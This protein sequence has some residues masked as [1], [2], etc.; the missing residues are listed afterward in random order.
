MEIAPEACAISASR[1][2]SE[3]LLK[4]ALLILVATAGL[5]LSAAVAQQ[6]DVAAL[7]QRLNHAEKEERRKAV[8]E[9][10]RLGQSAA[11][12]V[13]QLARALGDRDD[14]VWQGA[15]LALA[16][17]G[18]EA[19]YAIPHLIEALGDAEARY[20]EQ[21]SHRSAFALS[22]IGEA[23]IPAL[24]KALDDEEKH[25]R[26]GALHA[27][28]LMGAPAHPAL[29]HVIPLLGD[30]EEEVRKEAEET[31]IA[32]GDAS[33]GPI[34]RQL[35]NPRDELRLGAAN[36]LRRLPHPDQWQRSHVLAALLR[37]EVPA[38]RAAL[39]RTAA[40]AG[41]DPEFL[42]P[43]LVEALFG[44]P[45]EQEAAFS[46]V[47]SHPALAEEMVPTLTLLLTDRLPGPRRQAASLLGRLGEEATDAAPML[48]NRLQANDAGDDP[49]WYQNA[50]ILIGPPIISSLFDAVGRVSPQEIAERHWA[51]PVLQGLAPLALPEIEGALPGAPPSVACLIFQA[52]PKYGRRNRA[53]EKEVLR[54]L[55]HEQAPL[56][57]QAV[58]MLPRLS[59]PRKL[60]LRSARRALKD[61]SPEVRIAALGVLAHLGLSRRERLEILMAALDDGDSGVRLR[62]VEELGDLGPE[63]GPS[64]SRLLA[65]VEGPSA[66]QGYRSAVI[67]TLGRMGEGASEAAP[68]L[69]SVLENPDGETLHA[70]SLTTLAS[71]GEKARPALP[72]IRKFIGSEDLQLRQAAVTALANI[73]TDAGQLLPVFVQALKDPSPEV[74]QPAIAGLGRLGERSRG[75]VPT[76]VELLDSEPDKQA[77]F[78]ALREIK[79]KDIQL[80]IGLLKSP[81]PSARLLGCE[82]LGRLRAKQ[83]VPDLRAALGDDYGFV[84]RSAREALERIREGNK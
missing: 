63:A 7:G 28:A 74:R 35:S 68:F 4:R 5:N 73:E 84:R 41:S 43:L 33:R 60:S 23:A 56:R 10:Q 13:R 8:Y 20:I 50:L 58:K 79:P 18:P 72:E 9:L 57:T 67:A 75:A 49:A 37:E 17:I 34:V 11:P 47:I 24:L 66:S 76:L 32:L 62:A 2:A 53:L 54:S 1:A 61:P 15:T 81:N 69:I 39:L 82:R 70:I 38:V 36:V 55:A 16:A 59:L 52:L 25:R 80:C 78:Q 45:V 6:P 44:E 14:Q 42:S 71:I 83:A 40:A 51:V 48:V 19:S 27:L 77:A 64:V 12:V 22:R 65:S 46:T 3:T 26:W 31:C 29:E 30:E 21:R